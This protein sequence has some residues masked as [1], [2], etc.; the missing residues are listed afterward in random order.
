MQNDW[1]IKTLQIFIL[2]IHSPQY[3]ILDLNI[4]VKN[5]KDMICI[6]LWHTTSHFVPLQSFK[7]S[8]LDFATDS[9]R[10]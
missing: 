1:Q 8:L 9:F 4:E 10:L 6:P 7:K 5:Q 2:L 3:S